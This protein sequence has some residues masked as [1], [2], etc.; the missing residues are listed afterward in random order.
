MCIGE[1]TLFW[2]IHII[3]SLF[4]WIHIIMGNARAL[5]VW[6]L[7]LNSELGHW[8]LSLSIISLWSSLI[9]ELIKLNR[10]IVKHLLCLF[11]NS[12][13]NNK[14]ILCGPW[15]VRTL[16]LNLSTSQIRTGPGRRTACR[17]KSE[18]RRE[19]LYRHK[20]L[21]TMITSGLVF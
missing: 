18:K 12:W 5:E 2:R 4:R 7:C 15:R 9:P 11:F 21:T 8:K 17:R 14:T 10:Q 6:T 13:R 3:M 1:Y 16:T 19:N 20:Y